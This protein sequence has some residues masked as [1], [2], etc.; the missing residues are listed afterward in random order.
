MLKIRTGSP[1]PERKASSEHEPSTSINDA[2]EDLDKMKEV[3]QQSDIEF[4]KKEVQDITQKTAKK[5]DAL[6]SLLA[7]T[8]KAEISMQHQNQQMKS[9]L[10][11]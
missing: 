7:K 9:Y 3:Q 2:I 1:A 6:D 8:E 10:R 5:F 11:K 4:V